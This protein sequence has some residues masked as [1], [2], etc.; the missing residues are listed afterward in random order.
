MKRVTAFAPATVANVAVG[1]DILGFPLDCVGDTI[2]VTKIDEPMVR[3]KETPDSAGLPMLPTKNTATVG[4]V[5]LIKDQ[6]PGFGFEV[7]IKKG[8]P[9][10]SGMGGSAASSVGALVAANRFLKMPLPKDQLLRYTLLG[11]FVASG[12]AHPDN[13]TPCLY[14]GLTLTRS[15][16]PV[17]VVSLPLPRGVY[18]VLVRSNIRVDTRHARKVLTYEIPLNEHVRQSA[19]L[20]GFIA[21]CYC[22]DLDLIKKCLCDVIVEPQRSNLIP[23]FDHCKAA[24]LENG[25]LGCSISGSG[26]S[27]FAWVAGQSPAMKVQEKMVGALKKDG[28][29][30]VDSWVSTLKGECAKVVAQE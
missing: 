21:G 3:I 19:N 11:E 20:A 16:E 28:A 24:A 5:E 13:V 23:G 4:L 25:A 1:F 2:T 27:I 8:I 18:C 22:N 12:A 17:E 14:G 6:Q 10:G 30:H 7:E 29:S 15:I 9:I 26:P